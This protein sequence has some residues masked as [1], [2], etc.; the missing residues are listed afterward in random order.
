[1]DSKNILIP[2]GEG[3]VAGAATWKI[4]AENIFL[5]FFGIWIVTPVKV[6]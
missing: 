6:S 3:M 1:M 5:W 2:G 4:I